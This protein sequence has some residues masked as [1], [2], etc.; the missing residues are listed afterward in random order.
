[1]ELVV[2]SAYDL[3]QFDHIAPAPSPCCGLLYPHLCDNGRSP[4]ARPLVQELEGGQHNFC[5]HCN[6]N[7]LSIKNALS[8]PLMSPVGPTT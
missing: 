4:Q 2:L 8:D 5:R 6:T 7:V 3:G 1:M